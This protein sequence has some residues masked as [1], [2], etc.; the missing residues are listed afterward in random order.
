[1]DYIIFLKHRD[2][3]DDIWLLSHR[4]M[5][6]TQKVLEAQYQQPGAGPLMWMTLYTLYKTDQL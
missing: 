3:A 5:D 4:V 6:F 2:Y 1:M